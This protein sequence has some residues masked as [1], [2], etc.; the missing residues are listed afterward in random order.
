MVVK[1]LRVDGGRFG[2]WRC[3]AVEAGVEDLEDRGYAAD[4]DV[5]ARALGDVPCFAGKVSK[6]EF[7]C[8]GRNGWN[9]AVR[10]RRHRV[11][12]VQG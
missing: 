8:R 1:V 5:G 11:Q 2:G 10:R 7:K 12:W 6:E 4:N 9:F 3:F